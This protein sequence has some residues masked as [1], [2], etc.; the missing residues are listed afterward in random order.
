MFCEWSLHPSKC[1]SNRSNN[2]SMCFCRR[3]ISS[4][5]SFIFC[6][7]A[8]SSGLARAKTSTWEAFATLLACGFG[9]CGREPSTVPRGEYAPGKAVWNRAVLTDGGKVLT[10]SLLPIGIPPWPTSRLSSL[11]PAMEP[12]GSHMGSSSRSFRSLENETLLP[13]VIVAMEGFVRC[14]LLEWDN[15]FVCVCWCRS[16]SFLGNSGNDSDLKWLRLGLEGEPKTGGAASWGPEP[17]APA[18]DALLPIKASGSRPRTKSWAKGLG[19]WIELFRR[20]MGTWLA[21]WM[22][23]RWDDGIE[24]CRA[25]GLSNWCSRRDGDAVKED[26]GDGGEECFFEGAMAESKAVMPWSD[27]SSSWF[28]DRGSPSKAEGKKISDSSTSSSH[29]A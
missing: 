25:R 4:S 18:I 7:N 28:I 9:V 23:E 13:S 10:S 20:R 16:C 19:P 5:F 17:M 24:L 21:F 26:A 1:P 6:F 2:C 22:Y 11:R 29:P 15:E 14:D 12:L 8:S 3:S 27:V